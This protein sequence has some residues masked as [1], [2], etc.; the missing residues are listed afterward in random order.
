MPTSTEEETED[1]DFD[2][3]DINDAVGHFALRLAFCSTHALREWL[4]AR[5]LSLLAQRW[6]THNASS[7]SLQ[8]RPP[9]RQNRQ[10][11]IITL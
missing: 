11:N 1:A 10:H 4:V 7:G 5:E 8:S 3:W 9:P 6:E 2:R